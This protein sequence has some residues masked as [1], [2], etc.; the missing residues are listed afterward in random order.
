MGYIGISIG[1]IF[2]TEI[3]MYLF[4]AVGILSPALYVL[5]KLY[6]KTKDEG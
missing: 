6:K 2:G 3:F 4:G 1:S 5:E